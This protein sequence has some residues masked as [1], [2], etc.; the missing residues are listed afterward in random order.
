MT[1]DK[2]KNAMSRILDR[3]E[4]SPIITTIELDEEMRNGLYCLISAYHVSFRQC[5]RADWEWLEICASEN[6]SAMTKKDFEN[7]EF[8][9]D[10]FETACDKIREMYANKSS[11]NNIPANT[12]R[13]EYGW[14]SPSGEF[15]PS[16]FGSHEESADEIIRNNNWTEDYWSQN[17]QDELKLRRDYL[18][19]NRGYVLLHNPS[20]PGAKPYVT[21]DAIFRLT[22]AQREFLYGYF[23]D[24]GDTLSAESYLNDQ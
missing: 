6:A 9:E 4:K 17:L 21:M 5:K 22:K 18:I 24:I 2:L 19:K 1:N 16:P 14:L 3:I 12:K 20:C 13:I 8:D 15:L 11:Q 7:L 23:K 10:A